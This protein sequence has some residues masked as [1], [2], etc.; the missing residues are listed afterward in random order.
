MAEQ[1]YGTMKTYSKIIL[2]VIKYGLYL[3]ILLGGFSLLKYFYI[4]T[5][6]TEEF[7]TGL[8]ALLFLGLGLWIGGRFIRQEELYELEKK[9]GLRQSL[10]PREMEILTLLGNGLSNKELAERLQISTNTV[11]T[12]LSRIY[13]KLG[14]KSRTRALLEARRLKILK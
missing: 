5:L 1:I 11:K 3:T 14:V 12:H 6:L 13:E 7:Y 10:S 2:I 9:E 8:V 4:R